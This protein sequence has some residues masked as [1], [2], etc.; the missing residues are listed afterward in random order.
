MA[1]SKED[2]RDRTRENQETPKGVTSQ[3]EKLSLAQTP[4]TID[5]KAEAWQKV[6]PHGY[7]DGERKH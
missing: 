4:P 3:A 2:K 6:F 7:T 1:V 5:E